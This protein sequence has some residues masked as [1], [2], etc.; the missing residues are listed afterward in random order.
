MDSK[1]VREI[2]SALAEV[3]EALESQ[4]QDCDPDS[5]NK[6]A[7][8][9]EKRVSTIDHYLTGTSFSGADEEFV[10]DLAT[11]IC[12][13]PPSYKFSL[14]D[15]SVL[16]FNVTLGDVNLQ[17]SSEEMAKKWDEIHEAVAVQGGQATLGSYSLFEGLDAVGSEEAL[18]PPAWNDD[19]LMLDSILP[20]FYL[21]TDYDGIEPVFFQLLL[22]HPLRPVL[23]MATKTTPTRVA[24]IGEDTWPIYGW[25]S[26]IIVWWED[27]SDEEFNEA[28]ERALDR[29][30]AKEI[31]IVEIDGEE[32]VLY[33]LPEAWRSGLLDEDHSILETFFEEEEKIDDDLSYVPTR[34]EVLA[35]I[36]EAKIPAD[37]DLI[38]YDK[39]EGLSPLPPDND[40]EEIEEE[41]DFQ[42]PELRLV[43]GLRYHKA[44]RRPG[45]AV[46]KW[47]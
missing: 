24:T 45:R 18:P 30:G 15:N 36:V 28:A 4:S 3:Y 46:N 47:N 13:A 32:R 22:G 26:D 19:P 44:N 2:S 5:A 12:E 17:A 37:E 27:S 35:E 1:L 10:S 41:T 29:L 34:K 42:K 8:L 23:L 25:P 20:P 16:I 7:A 9:V 43:D 11:F 21:P 14:S 33:Q 40:T 38:E 39:A 31:S 6:V